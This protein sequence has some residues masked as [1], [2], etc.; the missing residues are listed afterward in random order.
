[1]ETRGVGGATV[2][3]AAPCADTVPHSAIPA[4]SAALLTGVAT[5]TASISPVT[6]NVYDVP[7]WNA[8]PV[9]SQSCCIPVIIGAPNGADCCIVWFISSD[10][11]VS[12][13]RTVPR[14]APPEFVTTIR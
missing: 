1:M 10:G 4:A 5:H 11:S 14:V 6:V 7:G 2:N 12:D 9:A 3:D 8:I 13:T